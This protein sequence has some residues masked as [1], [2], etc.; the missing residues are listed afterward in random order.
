[1]SAET[2]LA[3]FVSG[4]VRHALLTAG[5][6]TDEVTGR[7]RKLQNQELHSS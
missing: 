1:M 7:W 6:K 5:R 4:L 2:S 3:L